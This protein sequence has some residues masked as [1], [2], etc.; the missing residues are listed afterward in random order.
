LAFYHPKLLLESSLPYLHL[1]KATPS[2][3]VALK[4]AIL[5]KPSCKMGAEIALEGMP[6]SI[7]IERQALQRNESRL[8]EVQEGDPRSIILQK[9]RRGADEPVMSCTIPT[10]NM[11]FPLQL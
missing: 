2:Q 7:T 5:I 9:R 6:P 8:G 3:H 1:G 4:G 10:T 11:I